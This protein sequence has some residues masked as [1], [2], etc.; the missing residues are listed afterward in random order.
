MGCGVDV[1][2]CFINRMS[3]SGQ[4]RLTWPA[5]ECLLPPGADMGRSDWSNLYR[6][7]PRAA[8]FIRVVVKRVL[9]PIG[10]FVAA[11]CLLVTPFAVTEGWP[12]FLLLAIFTPP[13]CLA[14]W[15]GIERGRDR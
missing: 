2:N 14:V 7:A 3:E 4:N 15:L 1:Y 11:V 9:Q 10:Y 6:S 13:A 8:L 12:R 5:L